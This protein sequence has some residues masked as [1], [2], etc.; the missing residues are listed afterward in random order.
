LNLVGNAVKFTDRGA[1]TVSAAWDEACA[2]LRIEVADTGPGLTDQQREQLFQRFSQIDGSL[3]RAHGGTGL[4]LAICKGLV[5]AMGGEIGAH[6]RPGKG[7]A[8]KF[9]IPAQAVAAPA[10]AADARGYDPSS[11]PG[12]RVL[13][14][15]DHPANR[16][17]ATLF[18]AGIGAEVFEA[19]DGPE[20][21]EMAARWPFD[22]ILMDLR[23]P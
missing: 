12:L 14:V 21:L 16:E 23:M 9:W 13:V 7:S 19:S 3:S 18:L 20:A 2:R 6:S 17:L 4:G 10:K 8:F 22:L 5:E 11:A 1:V 15:D